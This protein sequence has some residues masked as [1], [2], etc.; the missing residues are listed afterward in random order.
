MSGLDMSIDDLGSIVFGWRERKVGGSPRVR[1]A[2]ITP[3][4]VVQP[5]RTAIE[6]GRTESV[7]APVLSR[8]RMV[9]LRRRGSRTGRK[10]SVVLI[11]ID[12]HGDIGLRRTVARGVDAPPLMETRTDL[13]SV[14][15]WKQR[16]SIRLVGVDIVG[17]RYRSASFPAQTGRSRDVDFSLAPDADALVWKNDGKQIRLLRIYD[18]RPLG[19][20]VTWVR[21]NRPVRDPVVDV[22]MQA[23][24]LATL[25]WEE[26]GRIFESAETA[27]TR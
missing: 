13:E 19:P 16:H 26:H 7:G 17:D 6:A 21:R 22:D 12:R 25:A 18:V 15:V 24:G 8:D 4:G 27:P 20:P 9:I 23:T 2:L 5:T 14:I 11:A 3:S 10:K 1:V